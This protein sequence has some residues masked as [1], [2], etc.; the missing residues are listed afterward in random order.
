MASDIFGHVLIYPSF[1]DSLLGAVL[2]ARGMKR[3]SL[4]IPVG[5]QVAKR[6]FQVTRKIT[7]PVNCCFRIKSKIL[8]DLV[9]I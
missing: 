4:D 7:H 2:N 9:Y 6:Q 1:S 5:I 3:Y 8:L